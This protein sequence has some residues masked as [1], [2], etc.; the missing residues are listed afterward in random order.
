MANVK[1][2]DGTLTIDLSMVD[3]LLAFH[4][5][6]HIPLAHV[7]NAYVSDFEDLRLQYRIGEGVNFGLVG[8][9][10]VFANPQSRRVA[11]GFHGLRCNWQTASTRTPSRTTSCARYPTAVP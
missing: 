11:S 7:T 3:S 4:G 8:T 6:F 1:I 2:K 9:I 5:S 10:G